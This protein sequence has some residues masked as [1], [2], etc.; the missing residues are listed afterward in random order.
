MTTIHTPGPWIATLSDDARVFDRITAANG[1]PV[2]RG[3]I[4]YTPDAALIAAA[5]DL[6]A[7]LQWALDQIE[8]D[9]DPGHQSAMQA[10][11]AAIARAT[12]AQA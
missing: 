8:D 6:L 11:R 9:L 5:P 1:A 3:H 7:A 4:G 12:G 2:L 10:A